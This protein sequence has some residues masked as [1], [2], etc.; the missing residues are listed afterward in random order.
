MPSM[1][2][3]PGSF[4]QYYVSPTGNDRWSGR[5]PEATADGTDGPW[6]TLGGARNRL[7]A[8][9]GLG[10]KTDTL[11]GLGAATPVVVWLRGGR[12]PVNAPVVF[13]PADSAPVTYAAYP[14]ETPILDGGRRITGWRVE[15]VNGR[16]A[17]VASLPEVA[18]GKWQF[19]Q[20]FVNGERRAR[21]RLPKAGL[22]RMESVPGMPLPRGWGNGGQTQF[23]GAAGDVQS[24]HNLGDV[25]VVYLHFWIEERS[26]ITAFDPASRLVTMAR[27][28]RTALVGSH[29]SQLADYYLD[30]VSEALTEPGEWY[31][32]RAAGQLT[33]LPLPG[34]D[35]ETTEVFAPATLQL[36]KLVG[37]PEAGAPV[38][39][40]RFQ[41]IT[42]QHTDWRH[43]GEDAAASADPLCGSAARLSRG[44]DA[45]ASQAACD[46]P[47]VIRLRGARHCAF[48]DCT[49]RNVGWYGFE[50]AEGC[51]GIRLV[52]NELVDLGAGGVKINGHGAGE[53]AWGRTAGNRVTDNHIHQA[54]RIFHSA[55][56]IL[57]MHSADNV[58][59]H[60]HI[61]DLFYSGIS[62]GWVWGYGANVSANNRIEKNHIHHIGQGLL[63]DMG[64]VY[65]L[66]IQPGTV[67]RG[68]LIHDVE[69]AHYGG[70]A[71][72][73]DEGSSHI[74]LEDNVCH[75]TNGEVFHQHYGR[76][77]MLRNNI[78]VFGGENMA[79][80]SRLEPHVGF[81]FMRNIVVAKGVPMFVR[82]YGKDGRRIVSDLN[83]FWDTTTT[84]PVLNAGHDV[85]AA[86][87]SF[88]QWR[89]LGHDHQSLVADPLFRDLEHFDFRLDRKSPARKLGFKPIDL[90]DV[91]PRPVGK[92]HDPVTC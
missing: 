52:G 82:N 70:W 14:G 11:A 92:R 38:E 10:E 73:T 55:I 36:L 88:A 72:Y 75:S 90:R 21:P 8:R 6:A 46:V 34:E 3:F 57:S 7:R 67:V 53:P 4:E 31:L 71:L 78:L 51:A 83:L 49:V 84:S 30:N 24:F 12:Y 27:P 20:L 2:D 89:A 69:K 9:K 28:S 66:G 87:L 1:L 59:A 85:P 62:C 42:F 47:G 79:A 91:G 61:H 68:N 18:A 81:T 74:V 29:G 50:L 80:Y 45:A 32:D 48:E 5:L 19:R 77:N 17:W 64:G 35:P 60:N 86:P 44:N 54:G 16:T 76:E 25:E 58:L 41:G 33:Y 15:T 22:F 63:S 13:E 56:G 26:P 65:L 23:V 43:P 40:L 39:F 37:D